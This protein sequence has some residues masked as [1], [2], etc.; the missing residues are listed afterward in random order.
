M[1]VSNNF[2]YFIIG[3]LLIITSLSAM[4]YDRYSIVKEE[5]FSEIEQRID[6]EEQDKEIQ[7]Q[8]FDNDN[9]T[10]LDDDIDVETDTIDNYVTQRTRTNLPKKKYIANLKIEKINLNTGLV[11][12]NSYY[13]NVNR[14]I[15]TVKQ[16]GYPDTKKSNLILAAHSGNSNISYFRY[17]YKLSI[18]D[19][20]TVTYNEHVYDYKLVKTYNVPKNGSVPIDRDLNKTCLT[21]ITCTRNSNTEQTVYIFEMYAVDGEVYE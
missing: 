13:N 12:K 10:S 8:F 21:L 4:L 1:K 17:L 20:A 16:S 6:K 5:V 15:L 3:I 7:R 11:A 18:G 14:N 2:L 9:D 19:K